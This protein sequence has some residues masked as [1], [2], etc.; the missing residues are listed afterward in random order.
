MNK[1]Y[2]IL[3]TKTGLYSTG[4]TRIEFTKNGKAWTST[5]NIKNHLRLVNEN[6]GITRYTRGRHKI[7]C[8]IVQD[9][10]LTD[11][12]IDFDVLYGKN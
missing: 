2:K 7:V 11:E 12:L 10:E 1:I 3:D 6:T 4:G 5:G 9:P 8:F